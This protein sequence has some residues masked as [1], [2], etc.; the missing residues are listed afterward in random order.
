M[1]TERKLLSALACLCTL[2]AIAAEETLVDWFSS[3]AA[4]EVEGVETLSPGSDAPA[5]NT[6]TKVEISFASEAMDVEDLDAPSGAQVAFAAAYDGGETN[7][8][9]CVSGEWTKLEGATPPADA[10][11]VTLTATFNY[12]VSPVKVSF[13]VDG[14]ALSDG[15]TTSFALSTDKGQLASLAFAGSGTVGS[16]DAKVRGADAVAANG[17]SYAASYA[18]GLDPTDATATL[19]AEPV[20]NPTVVDGDDVKVKVAIP[21]T[22]REGY[23]VHYQV[24]K[25]NGTDWV[26]EGDPQ[27]DPA[28]IL[29]PAASGRYRVDAVITK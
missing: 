16:V 4:M 12:A 22:P 21:V 27:T 2:G 13:A 3:S 7:Y 14:V 17:I 1:K 8:Y 18:L 20:D 23:T 5:T 29:V 25:F 19:K 24:K 10:S 28:A 9:A 15:T 6:I 26:A 11:A